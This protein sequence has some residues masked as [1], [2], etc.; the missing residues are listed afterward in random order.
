[1]HVIK[2]ML[3]V[4][5]LDKIFDDGAGYALGRINGDTW[6]VMLHDTYYL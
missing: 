3:Q 6:Y 4:Q 2:L 5:H 1:M